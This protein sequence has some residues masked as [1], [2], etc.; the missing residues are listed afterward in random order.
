MFV[1]LL[2]SVSVCVSQVAIVVRTA[3]FSLEEFVANPTLE[4]L[5]GCK[6]TDLFV[7][8]KHYGF[9]ASSSLVKAELW[10]VVTDGLVQS[11]VFSSLD[12]PAGAAAKQSGPVVEEVATPHDV[13]DTPGVKRGEAV[14]S[15]EV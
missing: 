7:I 8:A 5:G 15:A 12:L 14:H 13:T 2:V 3:A 6:K 11:G 9:S 10:A 4:Q 1:G